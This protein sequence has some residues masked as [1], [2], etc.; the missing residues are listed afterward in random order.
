MSSGP[1]QNTSL[2]PGGVIG[3]GRYRLLAQ[4][5][6][7]QRCDAHL[8]RARDGQLNRDVALTI[9]VGNPADHAALARAKRTVERAMHAASFTHPGVSRVIDVL[10]PGTGIRF[11]EGILGMVVAEWT[12]GTDLM[13][14][15]AE[16]PLPAGA[17]TRLLEPLGA[18]IEGAHHAGLV[19]GAD[20]P[21]RI[22][23]TSDGRLRLAFPGPRPDAIARDDVKG[24]G[25]ILYLLLTGRWALPGGP[26]GVPVA[27]TGPDGAVVAPS[28][29]HPYVPHELSSVAVRSLEDTSVGGIRTSAAI[30][31]VL[32]QISESEAQTALIE[33]VPEPGDDGAVWTTQRPPRGKDHKRKL[34][35]SVAV[36]AVATLAVVVWLG[37]QIVNFFSDSPTKGGG[38]TVVIGQSTPAGSGQPAPPAAPTPAG[39]V[40]PA[41]VGVYDVTNQPDNANRANRAVDN[42]PTTV[43]QT[44]NYFEPFPSLKPGIGLMASFAEQVKL[45]SV[46]V[47]SP[48]EGTLVEIRVAAS[49]GAP[50]EETKVIATATLSA[51]QTQIQL[52]EHDATQHV[53]VWITKLGGSGRNNKSDIAELVYTRAQ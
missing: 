4:S 25:A 20:H 53:L 6:T 3:D 9:L 21:Q 18:A 42:N 41:A 43:W 34:M 44:E 2:V 17:A 32:D 51:G 35:I 22:R 48:S 11:D 27:P 33:P 7:D 14:L 28:A 19:L 50:L 1:I 52:N 16:G 15:I 39:P 40:Q 30:L 8:W 36:L 29:L 31:Q 26:E 24:L 37:F 10:T 23:V 46:T 12:Q 38:P 49:E 13:D 5:G 47:T 45:A